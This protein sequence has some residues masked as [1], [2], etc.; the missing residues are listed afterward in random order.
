M[1]SNID[2]DRFYVGEASNT[3]SRLTKL[4]YKH[5]RPSKSVVVLGGGPSTSSDKDLINEYISRNDSVVISTN[6]SYSFISKIDYVYFGDP[7]KFRSNFKTVTGGIFV[8]V[9]IVDR[10]TQE[11]WSR[12]EKKHECYEVFLRGYSHGNAIKKWTINR[13][14]T[15]PSSK[16]GPS[17]LAIMCISLLFRP[18]EILV[19]GLDGPIVNR[20]FRLLKK[21]TFNGKTKIY[22]NL[23]KYK[24]KKRFLEVKVIRLLQ[25]NFVKIKCVPSSRF[26]NISKKKYGIETI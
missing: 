16:Y 18:E 5:I 6:Y 11:L 20:R 9:G 15:F 1:G 2:L 12:T 14:G 26:W 22:G 7:G 10:Y 23:K 3:K 19:S 24:T 17:G 13:N 4:K 25:E 21:K 8:S